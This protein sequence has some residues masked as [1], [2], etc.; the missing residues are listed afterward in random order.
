LARPGGNVTG[1]ASFADE[2]AGKRVEILNEV[3][4]KSTRIGVIADAGGRGSE[5][6]VKVMK[7]VAS[8]LGLKLV[9]IRVANDAEKLVQAFQTAVRERV[10]AIITTSGAAVYLWIIIFLFLVLAVEGVSLAVAAAGAASVEL[11]QEF[12]SDVGWEDCFWPRSQVIPY[13]TVSRTL[14]HGFSDDVS[15]KRGAYQTA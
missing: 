13:P 7:E 10:D 3:L 6:Q 9:E 1:L 4:P 12:G 2:L 11:G 8:A 5:L 15:E 14:F